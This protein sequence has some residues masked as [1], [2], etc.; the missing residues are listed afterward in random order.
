MSRNTKSANELLVTC[1]DPYSAPKHREWALRAF[2][3]TTGL[4]LD[5]SD[6]VEP[7]R[8]VRFSKNS[9]PQDEFPFDGGHDFVWISE[10]SSWVH[11]GKVQDQPLTEVVTEEEALKRHLLLYWEDL[12]HVDKFRLGQYGIEAI[13]TYLKDLRTLQSLLVRFRDA[14]SYTPPGP[15]DIHTLPRVA[16]R[17]DS[18]ASPGLAC[19]YPPEAVFGWCLNYV[20]QELASG[21]MPD[22]AELY[23]EVTSAEDLVRYYKKNGEANSTELGEAR[24]RLSELQVQLKEYSERGGGQRDTHWYRRG[25][26]RKLLTVKQ[27]EYRS[28]SELSPWND[29]IDTPPNVFPVFSRRAHWLPE[30]EQLLDSILHHKFSG[31]F[32]EGAFL[33]VRAV[34]LL[35]MAMGIN[36]P[37]ADVAEK[38]I[39][40]P[41]DYLSDLATQVG[42]DVKKLKSAIRNTGRDH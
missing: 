18:T 36:E 37:N 1:T 34:A 9:P 13:K 16:A 6:I 29:K 4:T 2:C 7:P 38:D 5:M 41:G 11:K 3:D 42:R 33:S 12:R 27:G 35:L 22:I 28:P 40:T 30:E 31:S 39:K 26:V 21:P 23:D 32:T 19:I 25:L 20:D 8:T 15:P 17:T 10:T 24:G 14:Q